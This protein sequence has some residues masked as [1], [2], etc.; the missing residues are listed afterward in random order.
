[1]AQGTKGRTAG[2]PAPGSHELDSNLVKALSHPLRMR[3]LSRLNETVASPNELAREFNESLPLLSYHV[4]ILRDLGCIELVRTTPRRGAIEHHYRAMTRPTLNERDWAQLPQSVRE[5]VSDTV[6]KRALDDVRQAVDTGTFDSRT[7]DHLT[8]T[9][10]MLDE[11]GWVELNRR[12][13]ELLDWAIGEQAEAVGRRQDDEA[14]G[15]EVAARLIMMSYPA[16]NADGE[17]GSNGDGDAGKRK[18]RAK[19]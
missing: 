12:M 16:P 13:I 3:I 4:R 10:L 5:A 7:D 2:K 14:G 17:D 8:F 15:P 1:M 18:R 11:E 9:S 19:R 6:L